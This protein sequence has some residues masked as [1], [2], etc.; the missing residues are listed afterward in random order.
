MFGKEVKKGQ[1]RH[2]LAIGDQIGVPV[3]AGDKA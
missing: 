1:E 3:W 2:H